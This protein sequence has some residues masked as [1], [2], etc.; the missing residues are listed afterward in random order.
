M[1]ELV[2][3]FFLLGSDGR[4]GEIAMRAHLQAFCDILFKKGSGHNN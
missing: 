2:D 3:H 1:L 4:F